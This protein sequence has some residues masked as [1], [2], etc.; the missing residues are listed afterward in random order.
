MLEKTKKLL[1]GLFCTVDGK[2]IPANVATACSFVLFGFV[3][4]YL[5]VYKN[6]MEW[7][8]YDTFTLATMGTSAGGFINAIRGLKNG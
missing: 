6:G 7:K 1:H 2:I 8:H 3:T 4:L 5:L